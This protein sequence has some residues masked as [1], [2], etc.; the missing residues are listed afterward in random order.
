VTG[1]A[2]NHIGT[3]Q[4]SELQLSRV[5]AASQEYGNGKRILGIQATITVL[6]GFGSPLLV[7]RFPTLKAWAAFYAFTVALL[8][9]LVLERVQSDRRQLGAKIQELFDCNLFEIPWRPLVAGEAPA[10]EVIAEECSRYRKRDK[11][12]ARLKDWY[13]P[14]VSQLPLPLARL[15]CQR[16]NAWWDSTLR[17]RYSAALKVM[18]WALGIFVCGLAIY[19][20]LTVDVFVSS[21]LAP[22][23]PA[24][25]WGVRE[26]RKHSSAAERLARLQTH[27]DGKWR[28]A[29][30]GNLPDRLLEAESVS[31]QDEIFRSRSSSPFVFNWVYRLLRGRKEQTMHTVAAQLVHE[32]LGAQSAPTS[33]TDTV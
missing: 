33:G 28:E 4:N 27:I 22:L 11:N 2:Q 15:V 16:T 3:D 29:L 9:A 13:S 7:A 23:T 19:R 21:V 31:I 18:V 24:I 8:D 5:A 12:L 26:I 20:G 17:K 1:S 14:T 32:A 25:L 10:R 30:N 6:G